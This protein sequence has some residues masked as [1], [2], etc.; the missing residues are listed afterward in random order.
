MAKVYN[1]QLSELDKL[2]DMFCA[3]SN[4]EDVMTDIE[5]LKI[6]IER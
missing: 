1:I 4:D 3:Y 2:L 6:F 5:N